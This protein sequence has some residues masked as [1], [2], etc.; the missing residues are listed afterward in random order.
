M[1]HLLVA[2]LLLVQDQLLL[3]VQ[4]SLSGLTLARHHQLGCEVTCGLVGSSTFGP[5]H[6]LTI[7]YALAKRLFMGFNG[8]H[9]WCL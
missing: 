1:L 2:L 5:S 9:S 7:N 3:S 8:T 6:G 4:Q